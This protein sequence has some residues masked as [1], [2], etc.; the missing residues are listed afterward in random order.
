M[1][2]TNVQ[3]RD[4]T[5]MYRRPWYYYRRPRSQDVEMTGY[6]LLTMTNNENGIAQAIPVMKWL[7]GQ[8][9][10][11]GGYSSTQVGKY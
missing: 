10:S 7:V 4:E 9:S 6:A 1:Y 3:E 11:L 8:R 5:D 2:W